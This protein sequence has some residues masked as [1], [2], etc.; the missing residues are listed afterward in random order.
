MLP[1]AWENKENLTY[2]WEVISHS[3][4][5][6]VAPTRLDRKGTTFLHDESEPFASEH[7]LRTLPE[8]HYVREAM[9]RAPVW[10]HKVSI[11]TD[12][13]FISATRGGLF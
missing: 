6:G 7:S 12:R 1:V 13:L 10:V 2:A 8:P 4:A 5:L 3:C 11:F 9:R